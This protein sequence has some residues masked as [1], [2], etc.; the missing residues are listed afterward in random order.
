MTQHLSAPLGFIVHPPDEAGLSTLHRT[1]SAA[2][3]VAMAGDELLRVPAGVERMGVGWDL[4]VV[5]GEG[6]CAGRPVVDELVGMHDLI[7][8]RVLPTFYG[9]PPGLAPV[10][11]G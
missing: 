6:P 8:D 9:I 5:F 11:P 2:Q 10:S 7:A 4:T 3:G 1:G